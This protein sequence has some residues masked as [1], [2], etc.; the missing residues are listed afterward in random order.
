MTNPGSLPRSEALNI[1]Y[2]LDVLAR[3]EE[4]VTGSFKAPGAAREAGG[5]LLGTYT[6]REVRITGF[7][8]FQP[9]QPAPPLFRLTPAEENILAERIRHHD[10]RARANGKRVV[11]WFHS[12]ADGSLTMS[13][14]DATLHD[15]Y[16]PEVWQVSLLLRGNPNGSIDAK[17]FLKERSALA[18]PIDP[19]TSPA[20]ADT[21]LSSEPES[22]YRAPSDVGRS[23]GGGR[24]RAMA[25]LSTALAESREPA[26]AESVPDRT[27]SQAIETHRRMRGR[28][29]GVWTGLAALA[30]L[31]L[32]GVIYLRSY[33]SPASGRSHATGLLPLEAVHRN[34]NIEVTWDPLTLRDST[35]G[36]L[37]VQDGGVRAQVL[38]DRK[39]LVSGKF[40]YAFKS[41]V[42]GFRLRVENYDG[43]ALEGSTTY[44]APNGVAPNG[45]G[46]VAAANL[47]A[48]PPPPLPDTRGFRER[49]RDLVKD[50]LRPGPEAK[51]ALKEDKPEPPKSV[52]QAPAPAK[53]ES[54]KDT[55]AD[56]LNLVDPPSIQPS[57][58]QAQAA[59]PPVFAASVQQLP[60]P[61]LILKPQ[62]QPQSQIAGR[63]TLQPGSLSRSPAVPESIAIQV[64]E[65]N[66]SLEGT[67][68]ARYRSGSKK[69]RLSFSF[70]GKAGS[71]PVRLPW[72]SSDGQKGHIEFLR[73]PNSNNFEVV[74][75]SSDSKRV[76]D[77]IV[78]KSN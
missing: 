34:G 77:E 51:P 75:Y 16:F 58:V 5:I 26:G 27:V 29:W 31:S 46:I 20:S 21:Q 2:D 40:T 37:D 1:E 39:T 7:E 3:I 35:Q 18:T 57:Q 17:F 23:R 14:A 69:E 32:A 44:V 67:L 78:R 30:A 43:S 55:T 6:G 71:G 9:T 59:P 28:G 76:Y 12:Q 63:W 61:Q 25:P 22:L 19:A 36:H 62:V 13:E 66:G 48:L 60:P 47:P 74:W 65:N 10:T 24:R 70:A 33:Y 68:D 49:A 53:Q 64:S 8:V 45:S 4:Q 54:A 52:F 42:T 72:S 73:V 56:R 41:D 15:R 38:L 11:G 50:T